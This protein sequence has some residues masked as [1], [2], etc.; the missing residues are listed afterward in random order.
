MSDWRER[1]NR[2]RD[3]RQDRAPEIRASGGSKRNTKKWCRGKVGVAH[4]PVCVDYNDHKRAG[5]R[6][7]TQWKLLVCTECNKE[8]DSWWPSPLASEPQTPPDWVT[9][10]GHDA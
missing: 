9:G 6:F 2:R 8:L 5:F 1:A 7:G 4:K 10:A 3:E